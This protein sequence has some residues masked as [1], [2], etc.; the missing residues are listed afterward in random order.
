M[1]KS[2]VLVTTATNL[3]SQERLRVKKSIATFL[4][5]KSFVL[6]YKVDP[7][8]LGGLKIQIGSKTLDL[9]LSGELEGQKRQLVDE[10]RIISVGDSV[11]WLDGLDGAMYGEIIKFSNETYG[12]VLN[13]EKDKLG[14][15][16]LGKSETL[17]KGDTA[18]STGEILSIGVSDKVLGRIIDPLGTP[19][20]EKEALV[21]DKL[22]PVEK[23]APSI[24]EREPVSVP[25]QTGIKAI[26]SMIPIG[27][28][29]RE[30]IIGDRSTGKTAIALDTI[31]NQKDSGV[32]CIYVAIG[33]KRA[34][35]AH[36]IN[37]LKEYD[38]LKNS[39]VVVA[40]ASDPAS[41]RYL[42]PYSATAIGEYFMEKGKDVLVIYDDLTKHAWAYR[43]ISLLLKRP[44]GREAYPGD[45]F[46]LHSKL[47]ERA[48]KLAKEKGGGSL[49][50]L[51]IVETLS[52]DVSSYIPT[53]VISITDGQ[54]YLESDLF[55]SGIRPALNVGLSV[56]RVGGKAQLPAMKKVAG[57]LRLDLSQYWELAT[58]AQFTT[59]LDPVTKQK[60]E[61]GKRIV[62]LLKQ[63]Q[64]EPMHVI[65]EVLAIFLGVSGALDEIPLE[66][67]QRAEKEFLG[68][69][70]EKEKKLFTKIA[71]SK[72]INEETWQK[73][74]EVV[75]NFIKSFKERQG[76][77]KE[78][79]KSEIN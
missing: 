73:L 9:S 37:K 23:I 7:S 4:G 60:I 74:T 10:G 57:R 43:E 51:P 68:F 63:P 33:Q 66:L 44:S 25:L 15:I 67:V 28:G 71:E 77:L 50:A 34:K 14:T 17:R 47:L 56:S 76:I 11:A 29:Q 65:D 6:E 8:L 72:D 75:T 27:R 35:I 54:I 42:A 13:L 48:C 19:L 52:G 18:I 45:I 31:I 46:Y 55:F 22:M 58:F 62:E 36:V 24:I 64:Y 78:N 20:D 16:I 79:E 12:L 38:V 5:G 61:R 30:L 69:I 26:D 32:I 3:S 2:K 40:S 21:A 1:R 70:K 39:V 41:L 53:N 49:T 59:D